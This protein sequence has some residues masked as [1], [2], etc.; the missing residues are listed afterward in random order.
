MD[1]GSG[2]DDAN[3]K[4]ENEESQGMLSLLDQLY[5]GF[6]KKSKKTILRMYVSDKQESL[7][8]Y[9]PS[10]GVSHLI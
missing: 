8:E 6:K 10:A 2:K 3:R 9:I 5:P 4:S 7:S 1:E